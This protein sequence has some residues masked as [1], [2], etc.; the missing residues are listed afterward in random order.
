MQVGLD[1][2]GHDELQ[3]LQVLRLL[4]DVSF[5]NV[6]EQAEKLGFDLT[7]FLGAL[8]LFDTV[9]DQL[10]ADFPLKLIPHY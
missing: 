4:E 1:L 7:E 3:L 2:V 10:L 8:T 6:R 9:L 5:T